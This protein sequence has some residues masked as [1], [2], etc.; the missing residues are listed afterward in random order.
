MPTRFQ[1]PVQEAIMVDD[2]IIELPIYMMT[3]PD[4]KN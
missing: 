4:K 1:Q 3:K 2:E